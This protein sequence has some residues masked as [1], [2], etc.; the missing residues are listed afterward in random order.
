MTYYLKAHNLA[1]RGDI[2][3]MPMFLNL[4]GEGCDIEVLYVPI[5][6]REGDGAAHE[7]VERRANGGDGPF[8]RHHHGH[9]QHRRLE[10][11]HRLG[12]GTVGLNEPR[13][14]PGGV[15]RACGGQL[16]GREAGEGIAPNTSTSDRPSNTGG[17]PCSIGSN[18]CLPKAIEPSFTESGNRL[19]RMRQ[20]A[21]GGQVRGLREPR[22]KASG[23][24]PLRRTTR[25]TTTVE[26]DRSREIP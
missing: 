25:P 1:I 14:R 7:S 22:A 20:C 2:L 16:L 19:K 15:G 18:P 13:R 4:D 23:A 8:Q 17:M 3:I 9:V 21:S 6:K 10:A 5:E 11:S 26:H 12:H 24:P